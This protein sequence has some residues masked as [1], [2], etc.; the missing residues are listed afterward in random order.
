VSAVEIIA[1]LAALAP[2]ELAAIDGVLHAIMNARAGASSEAEAVQ[3][4]RAASR[5][6]ID[7]LEA[8][9]RG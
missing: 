6:A 9:E 2:E 3:A 1:A 5:A 7:L 8:T 4:A